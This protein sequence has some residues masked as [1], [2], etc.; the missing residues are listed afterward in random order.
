MSALSRSRKLAILERATVLAAAAGCFF[1][2]LIYPALAHGPE[3]R[4][5]AG[6]ILDYLIL[7]LIFLLSSAAGILGFL[8]SLDAAP[9]ERGTVYRRV[10]VA[11]TVF[12]IYY[13][14]HPHLPELSLGGR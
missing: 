10:A 5:G 3:A 6:D 11:M 8:L 2:A 1:K 4:F 12:V 13:L 9:D 7:L 14:I